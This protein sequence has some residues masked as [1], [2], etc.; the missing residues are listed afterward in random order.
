M[1]RAFILIAFFVF[2]LSVASRAQSL[3]DLPQLVFDNFAPEIREQLRKTYETAHARPRDPEAVGRLGMTLHTYEQLE[4]A[5]LCYERARRL[6]PED[7]RWVYYFAVV[8][9]ALGKHNEAAA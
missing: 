1:T 6:A 8:K 2:A 7:F 3:P 4:P 5:A 9:A